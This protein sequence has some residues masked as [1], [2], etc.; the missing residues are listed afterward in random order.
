[1]GSRNVSDLIKQLFEIS[2]QLEAEI[3]GRNFLPS[4]QQLG[5]LGEVL[6]AEAF[7][8]NLC[9]AMTKGIDAHTEDGRMVQIKT[10]TSRSAGVHLSKRRPSVNTYLIAIELK[11]DGTFEVIYNGPEMHAWLVRQ[12]G[13][14]FVSMGPFLK[15]AEA[16]P[17]D[18]QLPCVD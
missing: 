2:R 8:L 12:S 17:M 1:M 3:P 14:P 15:A 16:I 6:V 5:N 10:V 7:G 13:K 9:K 11:P 4:G 18:K